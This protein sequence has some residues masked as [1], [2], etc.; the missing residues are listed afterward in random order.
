MVLVFNGGLLTL[1]S[2]YALVIAVSSFL[3]GGHH[4]VFDWAAAYTI[5]VSV[6]CVVMFFYA[7]RHNRRIRSDFLA[8]DMKGWA[9]SGLV[10]TTLLVAFLAGSLLEDTSYRAWVPYIDPAI[11]SVLTLCLLPVPMSTVFNAFE[12]V[13]LFAPP[14][15]DMQAR[16]AAE[17]AVARHGL[18]GYRTYVAKSD[19]RELSRSI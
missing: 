6:I 9:M 10:N 4:L 18:S 19:G 8:L 11:L 12:D 17:N 15:L 7:R 14:G 3:P 2:V 13:L 5:L 1:L 16:K